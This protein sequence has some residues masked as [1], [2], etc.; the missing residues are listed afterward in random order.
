MAMLSHQVN[1][2]GDREAREERQTRAT[3][4][5]TS[6]SLALRFPLLAWKNFKTTK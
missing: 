2:T 3:R 4:E 1:Q 6:S 5:G